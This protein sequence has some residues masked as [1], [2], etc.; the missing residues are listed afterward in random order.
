MEDVPYNVDPGLI[1]LSAGAAEGLRL[2]HAAGFRLI[3]ISNQSG[4]AQGRFPESALTGVA[5]AA[6]RTARGRRRAAGRV[7]LLPASPARATCRATRWPVFA[8]SRNPG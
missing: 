3:V 8:A 4:V 1:R 7:L 5:C 2:L 6:G